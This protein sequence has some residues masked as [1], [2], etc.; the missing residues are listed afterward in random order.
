[1]DGHANL[2]QFQRIN[3]LEIQIAGSVIDG[4][5]D[6]S[7]TKNDRMLSLELSHFGLYP[8]SDDSV[9][10]KVSVYTIDMD[11]VKYV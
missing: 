9:N 7:V 1:M 3:P 5:L 8:S 6:V 2:P 10:E 4:K 11:G